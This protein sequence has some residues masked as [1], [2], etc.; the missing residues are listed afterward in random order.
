[1]VQS[2]HELIAD[3]TDQTATC[4]VIPLHNVTG[5]VAALIPFGLGLLA[6]PFGLGATMWLLLAEPVALVFSG[7]VGGRQKW[8]RRVRLMLPTPPI[9]TE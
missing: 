9:L 8:A 7:V 3:E 1:M 6:E 2:F 5:F 4:S